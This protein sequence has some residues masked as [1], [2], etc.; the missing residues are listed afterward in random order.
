MLLGRI[1]IVRKK[2]KRRSGRHSHTSANRSSNPAA[3]GSGL[4]PG[5]PVPVALVH[6]GVKLSANAGDPVAKYAPASHNRT[7]QLSYVILRRFIHKD[8]QASCQNPVSSL[9]ALYSSQPDLM[10]SRTSHIEHNF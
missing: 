3:P 9:C 2:K 6:H 8:A 10:R 7:L 5:S 4:S 1:I